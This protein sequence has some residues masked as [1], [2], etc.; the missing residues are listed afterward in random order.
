MVFR[1]HFIKGFFIFTLLLGGE[2]YGASSCK[3][4]FIPAPVP[5]KRKQVVGK[6]ESHKRVDPYA[7]I[8]EDKQSSR[9]YVIE[10]NNYARRMLEPL[11]PLAKVFFEEARRKLPKE[12][13]YEMVIQ[14]GYTY[15]EG[16]LRNKNHAIY[17]RDKGQ[18]SRIILDI[19]KICKQEEFCHVSA[20]SPSPDDKLLAFTLDRKGSEKDRIYFKN[21]KTQEILP[22]SIPSVWSE[23][24]WAND[25]KHLFYVALDKGSSRNS[26]VFRLNVETGKKEIIFEEKNKQYGVNIFK[27]ASKEYIFIVSAHFSS[28]AVRAL[29][30]DDPLGKVK[31]LSQT[32][33][34]FMYYMDHGGDAF[35]ILTNRDG[36]SNFK[37]MKTQGF[38]LSKPWQEVVPH[39]KAISIIDFYMYKKFIVFEVWE[40]SKRAI[41]VFNR[42]TKEYYK[43]P[44]PF[45]VSHFILNRGEKGYDSQILFLELESLKQYSSTYKFNLNTKKMSLY[46]DHKYGVLAE[47][48]VMKKSS[49]TSRDGSSIPLTLFYKKGTSLKSSTPLVLTAYGSYGDYVENNFQTALFSLLDRGFVYAVAHVRGG[50]EKGVEWYE[51]GKMLNKKNTV[52]DF[53]DV[54]EG[55]IKKKYTSSKHL[56]AVGRSAGGYMLGAVLNKK[57]S[58]FRG[59]IADVPF[60]DV[61]N[62]MSSDK[63]S[64]HVHYSEVGNPYKK[65]VY[66]FL[67]GLSPYDNVKRMAY[68]H[69][70]IISGFNDM[71][72]PYW[73]PTRWC[74]RLRECKTD[75]NLLLLH[76]DMNRGHRVEG[77]LDRLREQA[78]KYSFFYHLETHRE[79]EKVR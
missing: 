17:T 47:N 74:A 35:Y 77:Y 36:A 49:I 1:E 29:S 40:N 15:Y 10:E 34:D 44:F 14:N 11:K 21:L 53:I 68:P 69:L 6:I 46:R 75:N 54:A 38:D 43:V 58:L 48:Y 13:Y 45:D 12:D 23:L 22:L 39:R 65:E 32:K 37:L 67:S 64:A 42:E 50:G 76:T 73:E 57:P 41:H 28:S 52:N 18:T 61:L 31:V 25:S 27:S 19:N 9:R 8:R 51:K 59:A 79:D 4:S 72:V 20:L 24:V 30:A 60:V 70:L 55:L 26:K 3:N 62:S 5:K 33:P 66:K 71:R 16:F 56:Y 2:A 63:F 78:L 7:W